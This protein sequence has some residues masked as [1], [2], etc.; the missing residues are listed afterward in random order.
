MAQLDA[1]NLAD[2]TIVVV[3]SDHGFLLGEHGIWAKHT[4]YEKAL[5]SPLMI[6]MP[7]L[8]A[9]GAQSD[10]VV[11]TV[12]I[13]PTLLELCGL[14]SPGGLD[15]RSLMPQLSDPAAKSAKPA[16]GFWKD[17]RTVRNE[18]WRLTV[19][20]DDKDG[21]PVREL[22]D[23]KNDPLSLRDVAAENPQVVA[24]LMK[25]LRPAFTE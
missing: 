16:L 5:K 25:R 4:L 17:W 12:D 6:R 7:G 18:R 3:W 13:Y 1:L 14:P 11:E 19:Y 8:K 23:L 21:N 2:N 9:P 22:T 10:S 24:R 15:G 20:P